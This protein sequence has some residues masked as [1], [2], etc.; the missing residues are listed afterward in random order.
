MED[1]FT[2]YFIG[3]NPNMLFLKLNWNIRHQ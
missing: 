1:L 3:H 2:Q